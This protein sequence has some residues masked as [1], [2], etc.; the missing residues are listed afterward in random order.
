[1]SPRR[2]T[3]IGREGAE[4]KAK[5]ALDRREAMRLLT[6]GAA[7]AVASCTHPRGSIVPWVD[8]P[9]DAA[10]GRREV[11]ATTLPLSGYGRG[12]VAFV[13]DGRPIKIE[14]NPRHPFSLGATDV[15]MEGAVLDLFDPQRQALVRGPSGPSTE[16]A[17]DAALITALARGRAR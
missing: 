11:F 3:V 15:F 6:L 1:M 14:G 7:A 17:A 12:A 8:Q 2:H 4:P 5:P 10:Q 9:E 13:Q 16:E